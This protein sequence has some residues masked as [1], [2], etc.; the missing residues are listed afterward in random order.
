MKPAAA[1]G[2][3]DQNGLP[4]RRLHRV[5]LPVADALPRLDNGRA[6]VDAEA[7]LELPAAI[8]QATLATLFAPATQALEQRPAVSL[9]RVDVAVDPF[10]AGQT[11][12]PGN[13]VGTPVVPQEPL[14]PTDAQC[15]DSG[16]TVRPLA[17]MTTEA[18]RVLR[19]VDARFRVA[20]QLAADGARRAIE[21]T[22][23]RTKRPAG[24]TKRVDSVS[25]LLIQAACGHGQ[26]HLAVKSFR[27]S[28]LNL[29]STSGVAIR[30]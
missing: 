21:R 15:V 27:L 23:D 5:D 25:F 22:G 14:D 3:R 9:I 2:H 1:L 16:A 29:F 12:M 20:A 19:L 13:L 18:M 11:A 8:T 30:S 28:R 24:I 17:S 10:M 4:A 6:L 26:L 7:V